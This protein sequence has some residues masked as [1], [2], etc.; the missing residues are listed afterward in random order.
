MAHEIGY[1]PSRLAL[2]KPARHAQVDPRA[3][4]FANWDRERDNARLDLLCAE[5]SRL[6]YA[7]R[8]TASG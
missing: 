2:Y 6:A 5:M 8:E 7:D 1:V 3:A 4:F